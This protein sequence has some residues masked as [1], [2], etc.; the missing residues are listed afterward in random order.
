MA[1]VS[2]SPPRAHKPPPSIVADCTMTPRGEKIFDAIR[3]LASMNI[4]EAAHAPGLSETRTVCSSWSR[5]SCS[6]S[7]T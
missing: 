5:P 1:K 3:H 2:S 4:F 7:K 6:A